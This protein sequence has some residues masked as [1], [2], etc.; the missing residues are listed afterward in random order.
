MLARAVSLLTE[1]PRVRVVAASSHLPT[2]AIGGPTGQPPYLNAA[3]RVETALPP[4]AL[5]ELLHQIEARLGR[6]PGA[7]W[8]ARTIDLDLL[9][10][11]DA[12][13][14]SPELTMPHPRMVVRRFV[15]EPAAEIAAEM[16]HPTTGWTVGEHLAHLKHSQP[17]VAL[18]GPI[19]AGKSTLADELAG[20]F[21]MHGVRDVLPER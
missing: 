21:N 11:G 20:R 2:R 12:V 6:Q 19:G 3:V 14:T 4:T 9:L 18:A 15:L 13:V 16:R 7:R 1:H 17:Y 10:Y 5:A 8:A